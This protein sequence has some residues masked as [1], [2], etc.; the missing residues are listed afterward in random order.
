[1]LK[2]IEYRDDKLYIIDQTKLPTVN[3]IIAVETV[4]ECFDAIKKLK[5]RGAPAIEIAAA[6]GVVLGTKD[7]DESS[8]DKFYEEFK[9]VSDYLA[10]SRPTAVNLFWALERMDKTVLHSWTNYYY[11]FKYSNGRRY[12]HRRKG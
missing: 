9:G 3:E 6:Y 8:F 1:M 11:W 2:T 10:S 5:V 7:A 4:E 12:S